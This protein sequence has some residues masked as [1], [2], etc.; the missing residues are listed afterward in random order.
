METIGRLTRR[1]PGPVIAVSDTR[2]RDR[3]FR[4]AFTHCLMSLEGE[5]L[6]DAS[7]KGFGKDTHKDTVN[8]QFAT[9][10]LPGILRGIGSPLNVSRIYKRTRDDVLGG[11]GLEPWR[12]SPRWILLRVAMQTTITN[13]RYKIFMIYF[14]ANV[15]ELAVHHEFPSDM[16]HVMLA[17]INRR[18]QKL[19]LVPDDVPWA[20]QAQEI[21][22]ESME[23]ARVLLAKRW[24]TVQ[25]SADSAGTFRLAELK[26]LKP[27][28]NTILSLPLLRPFLEKLHN[29]ELEPRE[30]IS[31]DGKCS[32]RINGRGSSLPEPQLLDPTSQFE[33]RLS[34][35]DL[36]LWASHSLDSWLDQHRKSEKDLVKLSKVIVWYM[37]TSATVY[38]G[39]PEGF[40]VMVLTLML[41]WTA[42]D[43]A[44]I[45]HYPLLKKFD[46]GFP[47]TLFDSLLL[48]KRHQMDRLRHVEQYLLKRKENSLVANPSIFGD[49]SSPL[50]FGAQYFDQ[51][52]VHQEL[53]K[54]IKKEAEH[55]SRAKKA[56]LKE[57]KTQFSELMAESN[58]LKCT[59][60]TKS[61]GRGRY[62]EEQA[63]HVGTKCT[64][65]KLRKQAQAL[66]IS[67]HEW[68]LP[69]SE[70]AAKSVVFELEI[71]RLI[72][73]W[74]STT[75]GI[76]ADVL[77]PSP[78]PEAKRK[79][80]TLTEYQGLKI[81]LKS[82]AD[83]LQL[84]SSKKPAVETPYGSQTVSEATEDSVCLPNNLRFIMQDSKS[85][86]G[87]S[88][89]LNK[90][91]IH[92]RCTLKLPQG[93]YETLQYALNGTK[94]TS[95]EIISRQGA[96]PDGLTVHEF[97]AFAALRSGHRL[98]W[99]NIAR[100]LVSRILDFGKEEVHLLLL[101][102]SWQAGPSAL[103]QVSRDS[104]VELE[105]EGFGQNLLSALEVGLTTIESNWQGSV[106][107]LT[108]VSLAARLLSISLHESV[109]DRC[110]KFLQRAREVTI[111]WLR[112][113][114][115]LLHD[116]S[117]EGE[118]AYLTLRAFDL[119][120]ICHCTFDIDP[121]R[122]PSL[123]SS[124]D[125][126][127][128][129][130]ET[131]TIVND[132]WPVS[133]EP[134]TTVTRELLRRFSRT[135]HTLEP[136]LKKQIIASP[137][138]INKAVGRMWADYEPGTPW[139]VV[140]APDDRW[141]MTHTAAS[142][143]VSSMTVHYNTLTGALLINGLPLAR[144]PREYESHPTY[145]RLFGNKVLEVIPS[146]KG[147]YFET[148][149]SVHG[150]Q[151]S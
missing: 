84:A 150:F 89:H 144:L 116:S 27:H 142:D 78:P 38:I 10:W 36:E 147:L 80:F 75:Y 23:S 139:V 9:E 30:K 151:V 46:P 73:H 26:K 71:P 92:E 60:I 33:I 56:E 17:K 95:N 2:V 58:L 67:C 53:K 136:A 61:V 113:V 76:L 103:R 149:N 29:I 87:T 49:I 48:P 45:S 74:R 64:K 110:L 5:T 145:K 109:R 124:A 7:S 14:M 98:Q 79:I 39:S 85:Q 51:S 21:V 101:Q 91:D 99:L 83:R 11:D 114:V 94:H 132:R 40:S 105:E 31:F 41:L 133:Q 97:H 54:R 115:K 122:L 34:L 59:Y 28:S 16:L 108:F 63:I 15:L 88:E 112:V 20:E 57:Y 50:S 82:N 125:N 130:I 70:P 138:G 111:K 119:A 25:R 42:L 118:M 120:L 62:Q 65:C 123:L 55:E 8:P 90:Y 13:T 107:A 102:A 66:K 44:A 117:D 72:R 86:H 131:S 93:C 47:P 6:D 134:L 1:F 143:Y 77:S 121:R 141:L 68:P 137:D 35:M 129:L 69:T 128:I 24:S 22:T 104:H 148:R 127:A 52:L 18:I 4:K 106:A 100:E 135:S 32:P 19:N 81:Y 3:N 96:C 12:R 146:S 37:S 126:V 43:E 140:E